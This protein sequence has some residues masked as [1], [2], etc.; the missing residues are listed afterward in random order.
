[1]YTSECVKVVIVPIAVIA[2]MGG[3]MLLIGMFCL[4][5][6]KQQ[7]AIRG[8]DVETRSLQSC[9]HGNLFS[10]EVELGVV[11]HVAHY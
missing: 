3:C 10:I 5:E 2:P 11:G 7:Q 9:R 4:V 6:M 8:V 1:M